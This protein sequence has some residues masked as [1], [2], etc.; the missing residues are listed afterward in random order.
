MKLWSTNA[1]FIKRFVAGLYCLINNILSIFCV[2]HKRWDVCIVCAPGFFT[3]LFARS[4]F[5]AIAIIFSASRYKFELI[6]IKLIYIHSILTR[7]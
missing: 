5:S 1:K 6:R 3:K 2:L 7:G 4:T